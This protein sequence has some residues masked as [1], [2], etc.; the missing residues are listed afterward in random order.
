MSTIDTL[1]ETAAILN[2]PS[3]P[4][5][6]RNWGGA[7]VIIKGTAHAASRATAFRG[8]ARQIVTPMAA[9]LSWLF[10]R[11]RDAFYAEDRLDG[12]SKIEFFGRLANTANR[13]IAQGHG[14][15][16]AAL[17]RAVLHEAIAIHEEMEAGCFRSLGMSASNEILDDSAG[18]EQRTGYVSMEATL[19]FLKARGLEVP[20]A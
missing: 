15:D 7:D 4:R 10:E 20:S 11:L 1:R 13:C 17:C 19:R 9:E 5:A 3:I 6:T 2:H 18:A 12:C 8:E 14:E 16:A